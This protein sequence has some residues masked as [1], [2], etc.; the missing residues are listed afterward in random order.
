MNTEKLFF[1]YEYL[2][3]ISSKVINYSTAVGTDK[4]NFEMFKN[5]EN[6]ILMSIHEEVMSGTY[7]LYPYKE[8]LLVKNKKSLPRCI[9]IPTLKDRILLKVISNFLDM[10]FNNIEKQKLPQFY[11]KNIQKNID[12][13]E[14][15]L[16]IDISDFYGNISHDLLLKKLEEKI[17]SGMLNM[18]SK[19]LK[20]PTG[21]DNKNE[22][23]LPQGISISN[24]LS[25]IFLSELDEK[26]S[27]KKDILYCRYVDDI[28]IFCKNEQ[29]QL[30]KTEIIQELKGPYKLIINSDKT[31]YGQLNSL[32]RDCP[33]TYL[34]YTFFYT[35]NPLQGTHYITSVRVETKQL[36]EQKIISLISRFKKNK[37]TTNMKLT[38]YDLNRLI[39]GS[40]SRQIDS[41]IEKT[42]RFGWL[43]FY[44]QITDETILWHFDTLIDKK[45][46]EIIKKNPQLDQY[47][48]DGLVIKRK[49]FVK[50]FYEIKFNFEHTKYI[51]N[52]DEYTISDQRS[53]LNEVIGMSQKKVRDY[54]EEEVTRTFRG[55]I[56]RKI[57]RD[58]KDLITVINKSS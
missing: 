31:K 16:K 55:F 32:T 26:Y 5:N 47:I 45:I 53:F 4:M 46:E 23:G 43:F 12:A 30:I 15:Y 22:K 9:S 8:L 36:M 50:A 19:A 44:S 40:V 3:G 48:Q 13:Y 17:S 7:K 10:T 39:T 6:K 1:S 33:L 20:T 57:K 11:I 21:N 14:C 51:F 28:L 27:Q 54:T 41:D 56:Y 42:K 25:H 34:G 24:I 37:S 18:I 29:L 2:E 38:L 35:R 52:P 49:K 58:Q